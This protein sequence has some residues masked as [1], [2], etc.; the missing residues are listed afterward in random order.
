MT[1]T[2]SSENISTKQQRIA[3]L[4]REAPQ[5]AFTTL[6]HHM[7]IGWL[8]EAYRR[9]RK[10]AAPGVDGQHAEE[11]ASNLEENLQSLL[12][13]AKSSDYRAP[14]V[15]R[16][17]IPKP[18]SRTERRPIGLPTFEDKVLQRAVAM[19]LAAVPRAG[20][21]RLFVWISTGPLGASG[22]GCTVAPLDG[23]SGWVGSRNR[24]TEM[25]RHARPKSPASHPT[26]KDR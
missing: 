22:L 17:Y 20:L 13:R 18:G 7:D 4:A 23:H 11:Y 6:A 21:S 19:V 8:Y 10:D 2:S 15:R 5:M 16:V 26:P 1:E 12:D 3:K 24:H 14:P 25:F 9:T